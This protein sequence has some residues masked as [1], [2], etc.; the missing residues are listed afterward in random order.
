LGLQIAPENAN[1]ATGPKF[2]LCHRTKRERWTECQQ[3]PAWFMAPT[4]AMSQKKPS[5]EG[6]GRDS[7]GS[8]SE[9]GKIV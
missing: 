7:E 4:P 6:P 3:I 2:L 9:K 5:R 8:Q 1:C